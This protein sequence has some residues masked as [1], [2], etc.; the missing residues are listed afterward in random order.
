M[1]FGIWVSLFLFG[2]LNGAPQQQINTQK[3]KNK[4]M[5]NLVWS[6]E[7]NADGLPDPDKWT[8]DQGNG[9]PDICGWGNNEL[10][11]YTAFDP[12]NA[13]IEGGYLILEA[14]KKKTLQNNF[15]SARLRSI[16][17]GKWLYG[18]IEVR[19]KL[20]EG[21]GVWPAIWMLPVDW[22]YGGWPKSGEIDIMEHV[23]YIRDTFY[24]TVHTESFNH[25]MGTHKSGGCYQSD[26]SDSFHVY[27]IIWTED[28]IDFQING[29]TYFT[30][31]RESDQTAEW[32]FDQQFY[33]ILNLA[34]GGN[35]GGK[36]G[37]D[38]D[39][40][41]QRMEVDYVRVY[42]NN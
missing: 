7:F 20:P 21:R 18:K 38:P 34:V 15:T 30:F 26:L 1:H 42:Q 23:G 19:A 32:P 36:K 22:T 16:S 10:Q 24:G 17:Y 25:L 11:Y 37:V 5:W 12:A 3:E 9:C 33:L 6:D 41:P 27:S 29:N 31:F 8:Y 39:I 14:H 4:E 28:S 2:S 35:W 40:W 13:R